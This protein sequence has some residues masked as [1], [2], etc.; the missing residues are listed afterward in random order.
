M[1]ES[2]NLRLIFGDNLLKSTEG[3]KN[4]AQNDEATSAYDNGPVEHG[5][6]GALKVALE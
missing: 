2:E 4:K 5:S 1:M 6:F 3:R